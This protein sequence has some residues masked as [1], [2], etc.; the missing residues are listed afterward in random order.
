MTFK[1]N[2]LLF[3]EEARFSNGFFQE[4]ELLGEIKLWD[5]SERVFS[6]ISRVAPYAKSIVLRDECREVKYSQIST[7]IIFKQSLC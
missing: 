3:L 6:T 7:I 5:P 2:E 4:K 1:I